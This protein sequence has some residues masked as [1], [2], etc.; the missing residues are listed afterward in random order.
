[1]KIA[2]NRSSGVALLSTMNSLCT[3]LPHRVTAIPA[4]RQLRDAAII[5]TQLCARGAAAWSDRSVVSV[6]SSKASNRARGSPAR[7]RRCLHNTDHRCGDPLAI[8]RSE[9]A[10]RIPD[11]ARI[12]ATQGRTEPNDLVRISNTAQAPGG[13]C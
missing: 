8:V 2:V 7:Q 1:M 3:D 12:R 6:Y 4:E 13:G 11:P 9:Q 10:A 5:G